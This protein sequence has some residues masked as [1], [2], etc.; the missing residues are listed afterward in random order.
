MK[1]TKVTVIDYGLG[2]LFSVCRAL[3]V[4]NADVI[5]TSKPSDISNASH[6]ILPGVGA[7][8]QGIE[9]LHQRDLVGCIQDYIASGRSFMGICLGMQLLLESSEEN[10]VH[11]GLGI[12]PGKVQRIDEYTNVKNMKIPHIGWNTL[13][14]D[15]ENNVE[16]T[17]TILRNVNANDRFYFVHSYHAVTESK[18]K[19]AI[20]KYY[21]TEIT[22]I[23]LKDNIIGCQFHPEKSR[24]M[25]IRLLENFIEG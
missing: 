16:W 18:Y 14:P 23:I 8:K 11:K 25:G 21:D 12:I 19:L 20:S 4:A 3:T 15:E 6:V 2:N 24:T 22:A 17:K 1:K 9:A 10:G 7:F 13:M 5:L